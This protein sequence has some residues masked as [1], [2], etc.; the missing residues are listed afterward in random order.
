MRSNEKI[1]FLGWISG[2]LEDLDM[3][4]VMAVV[5]PKRSA[6]SRQNATPSFD[7]WTEQSITSAPSV[8]AL[9]YARSVHP[10]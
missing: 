2:M 10:V 7:I 9:S 6:E 1:P 3:K 5:S 4:V 8:T